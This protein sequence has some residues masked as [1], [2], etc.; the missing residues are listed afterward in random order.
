M[1]KNKGVPQDT[2]PQE[3][4]RSVVYIGPDIAGVAKSGTSYVDGLPE[5]LKVLSKKHPALCR[6]IVPHSA[7]AVSQFELSKGNGIRAASYHALEQKIEKGE[8]N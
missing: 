7:L 5:E 8:L 6:L 1:P 3:P 2:T 4:A